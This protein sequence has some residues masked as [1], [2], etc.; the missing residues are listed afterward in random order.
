MNFKKMF[1]SICNVL[2]IK[3][4]SE[5]KYVESLSLNSREIEYVLNDPFSPELKEN[6]Q[7]PDLP[8]PCPLFTVNNWTVSAGDQRG[9]QVYATIAFTLKYVQAALIKPITRWAATNN[10]RVIP[11]AGKDFNAYYDRMNLKFFYDTD[12]TN[13]QTI[14]TCD[15]PDIVAHELGHAILDAVRPDLWNTQCL[16][17]SAFHEAFGDITAIL[18]VLQHN[19]VV[20]AALN[21]TNGDIGKSNLVSRLAEQM[22]HAIWDI[23]GRQAAFINALRNAVNDFN[24]VIPESLPYQAADGQLAGE[25]HSFSRVFVGAWYDILVAM[26][27]FEVAG[28]VERTVAL[29]K[30]RDVLSVIT[31]RAI[32]MAPLVPRFY[33]AIAKSMMVVAKNNYQQYEN[34]IKNCFVRRGIIKDEVRMLSTKKLSDVDISHTDEVLSLRKSTIVRKKTNNC[35][36]LYKSTKEISALSVDMSHL[37]VEVANESYMEFDSA[38]NLVD[39]IDADSGMTYNCAVHAVKKLFETNDVE[40]A[41]ILNYDKVHDK[42]FVVLGNKLTRVCFN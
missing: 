5:N 2:F 20:I 16:E 36:N 9:S 3:D 42:Q 26:Y 35:M 6:I 24:Y 30:I 7:I 37:E 33:E 39:Q 1:D 8:S 41:N 21:E 15:S 34:V 13:G 11:L 25:C 10:L 18:E 32:S 17:T 23:T 12:T 29:M 40:Y 4:N 38:G 28:G 14:Y 27:N 22:G 19:A 31:L